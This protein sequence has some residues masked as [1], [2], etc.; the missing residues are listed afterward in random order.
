MSIIERPSPEFLNSKLPSKVAVVTGSASGIG[1]A[2]AKLLA[3]YGAQVVV[4][5][6][7]AAQS[8][9]AADSIGHGAASHAC[10]VTSWTQQVELF[11]WV[12]S[13][14]GALDVV[15]CNAGIDPEVNNT[16]PAG[17]PTKEKASKSVFYDFSADEMEE[18]EDGKSQRLKAPPKTIFDVN[19]MG[20]IYNLKL[21]MHHMKR[22][23]KGGRIIF[24]GS[25]NSYLP[26][27]DTSLYCASKHAILG[28]MRSASRRTDCKEANITISLL[29]PWTTVTPLTAP[30]LEL[31]PDSMIVKSVPEDLAWAVAYLVSAEPDK[32]NGKGVWVQGQKMKE[33]EDA[34]YDFT[35]T[36]SES[37]GE[38]WTEE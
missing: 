5:D 29:V 7:D 31:I 37:T 32:V 8:Q 9:K 4:V 18:V 13:K 22:L 35:L 36:L 26:L 14:F 16:F 3:E 10:D 38:K 23:A 30:I 12:V 34:Y 15:I 2:T 17:H 21:A 25:A 20:P 11:E 27:S 6:L 28:L 24:V 19:L 33:V 1:Y